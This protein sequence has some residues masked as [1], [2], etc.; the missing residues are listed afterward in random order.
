M[1]SPVR[2][3]I[4]GLATLAFTGIWATAVEP[5]AGDHSPGHVQ[6]PASDD[7]A[8]GDLILGGAEARARD[9]DFQPGNSPSRAAPRSAPRISC[10]F[11]TVDSDVT[12]GQGVLSGADL[13]TQYD[14]AV[15]NGGTFFVYRTCVDLSSGEPVRIPGEEDDGD[16]FPWA[17]GQ[18]DAPIDPAVLADIARSRLEFPQPSGGMT[19]PLETGTFAQLDT[20]FFVDNWGPVDASATAGSVTATVTA[21][22]IHQAWAISDTLRGAT[23]PVSCDG[24]GVAFDPASGGEAP[25]G[26]CTWPPPHSSAGQSSNNSPSGQACF[27]ATVTITWD[28][29]WTAEGAPGGGPLG[30]GT[31]SASTCIVV[32]EIQA[33]VTD[34]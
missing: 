24:P 15:A 2:P 18:G 12:P 13:R 23:Y 3:I 26:A 29:S 14:A 6:V 7:E 10:S 27:S 1:R 25:P 8:W 34:G 32:Q 17:P 31:S 9:T 21:T 20:Y 16:P 5:A 11:H 4:A 22:P 28:V 30:T 19:P 33:V